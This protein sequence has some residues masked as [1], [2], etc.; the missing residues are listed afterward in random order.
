MKH[1]GFFDRKSIR[2]V[3]FPDVNWSSTRCL[4]DE[5]LII[6][7]GPGFSLDGCNKNIVQANHGSRH[8]EIPHDLT[9]FCSLRPDL[10]L[11]RLPAIDSP[12]QFHGPSGGD[13]ILYFQSH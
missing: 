11:D 7:I 10:L 9:K 1:L 2:L 6:Y 12:D 3:F 13:L 5:K 8:D 4:G